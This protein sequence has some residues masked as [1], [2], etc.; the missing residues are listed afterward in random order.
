MRLEPDRWLHP[1]VEV[2]DSPIAG[3]G[4][5]AR[6]PLAAGVIVSRLGGDIVTTAQLRPHHLVERR[7]HTPGGRLSRVT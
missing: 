6:V 1:D 7:R 4:L 3:L 2:Q 5:F